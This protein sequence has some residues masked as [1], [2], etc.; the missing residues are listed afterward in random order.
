MNNV[1]LRDLQILNPLSTANRS[2]TDEIV[3]VARAIPGLFVD[4]EI[5]KLENEWIL[6]SIE[7]IERS[8]FVKCEYVDS[9]G[10]NHIKYH[11]IDHY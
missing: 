2:S 11:R 3:R 5:D 9:D 1:L 4:T 8:W 10:S 6:Y 7:T